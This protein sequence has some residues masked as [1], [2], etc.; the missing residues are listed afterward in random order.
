ML[1]NFIVKLYLKYLEYKG[2][3]HGKNFN[4]EKGANIDSQFCHLISCGDNVTLAKDVYILAHDASM[5]KFLGKTKVAKTVVGNNVFI[6]AYSIVL[7]GCHIG[8]NV[9]IATNS[10]VVCDIPSGEVWGGCPAKYIMNID[11]FLKKHSMNINS[12]FSNR[13]FYID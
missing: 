6:G 10:S 2:F 13:F 7:P 1:G 9:I 8:D 4:L 3:H 11:S 12:K 5:K